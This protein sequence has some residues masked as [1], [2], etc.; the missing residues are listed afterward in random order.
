[1]ESRLRSSRRGEVKAGSGNAGIDKE[2]LLNGL[3][4]VF[5]ALK[6]SSRQ[7]LRKLRDNKMEGVVKALQQALDKARHLDN[8]NTI[9]I[10]NVREAFYGN[11]NINIDDLFKDISDVLNK[12]QP[13]PMDKVD[14]NIKN[15]V[16]DLEE[17]ININA[18]FGEDGA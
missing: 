16:V 5:T 9:L 6:K 12:K 13:N 3:N 15:K 14:E 10:N 18:F 7:N 2:T 11:P 1:M 4:I 8:K 17:T